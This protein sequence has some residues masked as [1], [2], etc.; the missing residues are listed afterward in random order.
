MRG[1]EVERYGGCQVDGVRILLFFCTRCNWSVMVFFSVQTEHLCLQLGFGSEQ[2]VRMLVMGL[3]AR[4]WN[5][6]LKSCDLGDPKALIL[7][8]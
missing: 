6:H 8:P 4:M 3:N 1:Y 2:W 5:S 7:L